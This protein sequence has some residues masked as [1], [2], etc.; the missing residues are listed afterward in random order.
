MPVMEAPMADEHIPELREAVRRRLENSWLR[1]C[2]GGVSA[3]FGFVAVGWELTAAWGCAWLAATGL[4]L[5]VLRWA[6]WRGERLR[7][8]DQWRVYGAMSLSALAFVSLSAVFWSVGRHGAGAAAV[9][10]AAGA[11]FNSFSVGPSSRR[12]FLALAGPSLGVLNLGALMAFSTGAEATLALAVSASAFAVSIAVLS[13]WGAFREAYKS[14]R[15]VRRVMQELVRTTEAATAAKSEFV[16]LVS[17]ELRTPLSGIVAAG[18]QLRVDGAD[19][20]TQQ[21]AEVVVDSGRFMQALLDD[22]LDLAKLEAGRMTVEAVDYD[23]GRL[24]WALERHWGAAARAAGKPLQ[25]TQA[26]GLPVMVSGD[27]TRLRQILNNLMSNALKFTGPEGV[28][29]TVDACL[30]DSCST[31]GASGLTV[32]VTDT[33]PGMTA[34]Q[35]SRLFTAFDQ[36]TDTVARTHGGTGLGLALSRELARRMGGD[37]SV[38][39]ES[40]RG[41]TFIL[42]LPLAPASGA[43]LRAE[44]AE[45][46][47]APVDAALR[48]LVVDDHPLNRRTLAL[49]LEPIG[50]EVTAVES[51]AEALDLLATSPFDVVLSDLHMP[52]MNGPALARAI[53]AGAGPNASAPII[54]VT[55]AD[56]AEQRAVCQEAGMTG[57]VSKPIQAPVLY[58]ALEAALAGSE[59]ARGEPKA[60]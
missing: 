45:A 17:H 34:E 3:L 53:R 6:A 29:W 22:L 20:L 9:L 8:R 39:S 26:T 54:A 58:A 46:Q 5:A 57:F 49:L 38:E 44:P 25:L 13:V 2:V 28:S 48:V 36:T 24:I 43:V 42:H 33:G 40:G 16:A 50:A 51:S 56:D 11:A 4:E 52:D 55:G 59:E 21:A 15:E 60:A 7:A 1:A 10:I 30:G 23:I 41:S 27:P 18:G 35:L 37:L 14:E 19:R 47:A 32:R 12:A 31:L